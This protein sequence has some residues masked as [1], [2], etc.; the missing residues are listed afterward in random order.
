MSAKAARSWLFALVLLC[1]SAAFA[2]EPAPS[3]ASLRDLLALTRAQ[4]TL[5]T[6]LAQMDAAMETSMRQ[7]MEGQ[8]L[9]EAQRALVDQMR[10]E[11]VA[12]LKAEMA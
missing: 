1:S 9:S 8:A 10:G 6:M 5:D 2:A 12:L 4:D 7:A 3:E 11:M